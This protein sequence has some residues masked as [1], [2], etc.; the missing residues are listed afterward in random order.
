MTGTQ[1]G[2]QANWR[3]TY[4]ARIGSLNNKFSGMQ[5][6]MQEFLPFQLHDHPHSH[7]YSLPST[8]TQAC[9]ELGCTPVN[10]RFC[11][12]S[13]V[14]QI[15]SFSSSA[16]R[17]HNVSLHTRRSVTVGQKRNC[18]CLCIDLHIRVH[19]VTLHPQIYWGERCNC[20][21]EVKDKQHHETHERLAQTKHDTELLA[22]AKHTFCQ[23]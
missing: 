14:R 17:I 9:R 19:A 1:A 20:C 8:T 4:R 21:Y 13:M 3:D 16:L 5:Q 6:I 18:I 15:F 11:P 7:Y 12:F 10:S 23:T 2:L 22:P